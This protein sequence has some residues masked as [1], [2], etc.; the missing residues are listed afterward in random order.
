YPYSRDAYLAALNWQWLIV[1]GE[2]AHNVQSTQP[3]DGYAAPPREFLDYGGFAA[4]G[5]LWERVARTRPEYRDWALRAYQ[6]FR[7]AYREKPQDRY[8]AI[9]DWVER[10]FANV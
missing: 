5:A 7:S 8:K 6:K 1:R 2:G 4:E 10:R 9:A 3:G